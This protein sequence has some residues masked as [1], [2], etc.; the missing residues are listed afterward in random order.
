MADHVDNIEPRASEVFCKGVE[1]SLAL[2]LQ[3][4]LVKAKQGFGRQ[5]HTPRRR[6][7]R[8]HHRRRLHHRRRR[9]PHHHR[10]WRGLR[11]DGWHVSRCGHRAA[12]RGGRAAERKYRADR[13]QVD[14]AVI[15]GTGVDSITLGLGAHQEC[16]RKLILKSDTHLG[17]GFAVGDVWAQHVDP[18][19]AAE[20]VARLRILP[21]HTAQYREA[22][23]QGQGGYQ[24]EVEALQLDLAIQGA[25]RHRGR[26]EGVLAQVEITGL[27][28]NAAVELIAE[29]DLVAAVAVI[30]LR[31]AGG[32]AAG[33]QAG[34]HSCV[35]KVCPSL[36]D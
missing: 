20:G 3:V 31:G 5:A 10:Q 2:R 22:L 26:R 35:V 1:C 11:H 23:R 15:A 36:P 16:G 19:R 24:V 8:H 21:A 32:Q 13:I 4:G 29:E 25:G 12:H 30:T 27:Q 33:E 28:S 17:I 14:V 18:A 6:R 34:R 7:W 9:G